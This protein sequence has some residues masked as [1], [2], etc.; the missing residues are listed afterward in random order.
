MTTR[1]IDKLLGMKENESSIDNGQIMTS[2]QIQYQS[3]LQ[4]ITEA[5]KKLSLW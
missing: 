2:L 5:E 3:D 4:I 1:S